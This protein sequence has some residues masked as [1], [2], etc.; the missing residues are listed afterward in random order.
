MN[1]IA[2]VI[3]L[4]YL[5]IIFSLQ[6]L[7]CANLRL[8]N[9]SGYLEPASIDD[10]DNIEV[11]FESTFYMDFTS[12]LELV[13]MY[14]ISDGILTLYSLQDLPCVNLDLGVASENLGPAG[15]N[16]NSLHEVSMCT[17]FCRV[18]STQ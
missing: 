2:H 13:R 11:C 15:I 7:P 14:S 16:E 6:D 4:R 17:L 1:F 12:G 18:H 5:N 10:N 9:A 3:N 8:G